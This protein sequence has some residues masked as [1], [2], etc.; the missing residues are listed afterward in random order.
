MNFPSDRPRSVMVAPFF[1]GDFFTS[2]ACSTPGPLTFASPGSTTP[3]TS[4]TSQ[5]PSCGVGSVPAVP[6]ADEVIG[7]PSVAPMAIEASSQVLSESIVAAPAASPIAS[8]SAAAPPWTLMWFSTVGLKTRWR[9][10]L[11]EVVGGHRGLRRGHRDAHLAADSPVSRPRRGRISRI[12]AQSIALAQ[13]TGP[14]RVL[15]PLDGRRVGPPRPGVELRLAQLLV[16]HRLVVAHHRAGRR[17]CRPAAPPARPRCPM[18]FP[19]ARKFPSIGSRAQGRVV[20]RRPARGLE[21][22]ARATRT[23]RRRAP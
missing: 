10:P 17:A 22:W 18:V 19:R 6:H 23:D 16:E 5:A 1:P 7:Y 9:A 8:G 4:T 13:E 21:R 11:G 14:R 12:S 15:Q 2:I 3:A 20:P